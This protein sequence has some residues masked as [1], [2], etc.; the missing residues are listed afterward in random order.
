MIL[1]KVMDFDGEGEEQH[2]SQIAVNV[3][4]FNK[5][6]EVELNLDYHTYDGTQ[7]D[8]YVRFKLQDLLARIAS[9]HG[10]AV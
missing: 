8:I 5:L 7:R 1:V 10:T 3:T 6:G 2:D 4:D 9:D